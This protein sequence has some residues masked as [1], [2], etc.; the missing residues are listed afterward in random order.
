MSKQM[1]QATIDLVFKVDDIPKK[2]FEKILKRDS[3]TK[4]QVTKACDLIE[5]MLMWNPHERITADKALKHPFFK[6]E[7]AVINSKIRL[8]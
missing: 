2:S 8:Y 6:W 1:D 4:D 3:F 7:R 5:K